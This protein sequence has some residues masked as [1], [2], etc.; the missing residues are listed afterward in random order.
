MKEKN[1]KFRE[2]FGALVE[3]MTD[4]QAGEF[5][6]AVSGYMFGGKPM[7]SKDEYLKGVFLYVQNV[8]D[9]EMRDRENGKIGG[10]IVA[11]KYKEMR[12]RFMTEET[13]VSETNVVSQ[14]IIVSTDAQGAADEKPQTDKPVTHKKRG[15]RGK[16]ENADGGVK[17][18]DANKDD[19]QAV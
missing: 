4:K 7:E 16:T 12:S 10:A 17:S 18:P 2:S 11:E 13:M 9:T 6:K 3:K 8:L 5:I 15:R 19:Q 1:F 14:L